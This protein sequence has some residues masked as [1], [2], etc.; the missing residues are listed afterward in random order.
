MLDVA[1]QRPV[2]CRKWWRMTC[3][4][5]LADWESANTCRCSTFCRLGP[6]RSQHLGRDGGRRTPCGAHRVPIPET[7]AGRSS[8]FG[9]R[10]RCFCALDGGAVLGGEEA[11]LFDWVGKIAGGACVFPAIAEFVASEPEKTT[12]FDKQSRQAREEKALL[13]PG[14]CGCG[15]PFTTP[16]CAPTLLSAMASLL[17]EPFSTPPWTACS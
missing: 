1:A 16:Q 4:L 7:V 8:C 9:P 5:S 10:H 17:Q 14:L 2:S 15:Y 6:A 12:N 3:R 13:Q 11:D